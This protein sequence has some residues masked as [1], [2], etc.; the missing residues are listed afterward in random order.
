[1]TARSLFSLG[2]IVLVLLLGVTYMMGRVLHIDPTERHISVEMRL[3]SSGGLG[4]TARVL[5]KGTEVGRVDSVRRQ[6]DGVRVGLR[7]DS[8]YRIPVSSPVRIEQL[9]A[10]GEPYVEFDPADDCGPYLENG[11]SVSA[12]SI[13]VPAT[14]T[15]LSV[16][17]VDLLDQVDPETIAQL[18]DT[19][20]RA[21]DGTDDAV[22]TLRQS[23]ALLAATIL[24]RKDSIRQLLANLQDMGSDIAWLGPSLAEAGPQFGSFGQALSTVI[25]SAS[26]FV[27]SRPTTDYFT[28]DGIVPFL[29]NL[30]TLIDELGPDIARSLPALL[31]ALTEATDR[32][33]VI[34]ISALIRQAL[35]SVSEDGALQFRI[36]VK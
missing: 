26:E 33:P 15:T 21:L 20:H 11:Q 35:H 22:R 16:R 34:D 8:R 18:V 5:L 3:D 30:T 25:Q 4:A 6:A 1:M 32:T 17:L 23:N 9:S 19:F 7:I 36:A 2:S 31:P 29:G 27:E 12:A 28:G 24:S 10:L 14:I 13:R